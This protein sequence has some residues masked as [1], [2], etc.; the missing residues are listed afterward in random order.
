MPHDEG[1]SSIHEM[2]KED[3]SVTVEEC[4]KAEVPQDEGPRGEPEV[5]RKRFP[6]KKRRNESPPRPGMSVVGKHPKTAVAD[7]LERYL[8]RATTSDDIK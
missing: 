3:W 6:K 5:V 2:E 4:A 7:F 1:M 8:N